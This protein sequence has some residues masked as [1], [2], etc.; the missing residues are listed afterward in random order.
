MGMVAIGSMRRGHL[1]MFVSE[2]MLYDPVAMALGI[3]VGLAI[4]MA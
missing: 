2:G 1:V 3:V 4:S